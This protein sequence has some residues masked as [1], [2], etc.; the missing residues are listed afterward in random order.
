MAH[1]FNPKAFKQQQNTYDGLNPL[2]QNILKL[3]CGAL[4]SFSKNLGTGVG[5]G[6]GRGTGLARLARVPGNSPMRGTTAQLPRVQLPRPTVG[7]CAPNMSSLGE[8]TEAGEGS[9]APGPAG[10]PAAVEKPPQDRAGGDAGPS[11]AVGIDGLGQEAASP[12]PEALEAAPDKGLPQGL[13]G[14]SGAEQPAPD[15]VAKARVRKVDKSAGE[16][17]AEKPADED[18]DA[19]PRLPNVALQMRSLEAIQ[20]DLNTVNAQADRALQQLQHKY[21]QLRQYYLERRNYVIQSIPGFWVTALRNHPQLFE[22]ITGRDAEMLRYITNLEVKESRLS[23]ASCRFKFFFRRNPF[24]RNTLI[25]KDY[26]VR[27]TG[28][29]VSLSTPIIWRPGHEPQPFLYGNQEVTCSFF[30]WL[31]DHSHPER[32]RIAQII[33][34][35]LWPNPLQ[36][37]PFHIGAPR[38]RRHQIREPVEIPRPFGFQSG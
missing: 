10:E 18:A 12:P 33:K 25:V 19:G 34:E 24:F 22:M 14:P 16:E 26:E 8:P 35:D 15:G 27:P 29:V 13:P 4:P 1:A 38:A 32:D 9:V 30:T 2:D 7:D 5:L 28:Q 37:Y 31:S 21:G 20:L 23:R 6:S 3:S 17:G 11:I 36:Y